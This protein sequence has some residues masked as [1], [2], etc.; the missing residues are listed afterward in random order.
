MITAAQQE[1]LDYVAAHPELEWVLHTD[2]KPNGDREAVVLKDSI[3]TCPYLVVPG[4]FLWSDKESHAFFMASDNIPGHDRELRL[5][6]LKACR[7]VI[8]AQPCH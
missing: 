5:A 1:I 2:E 8:E 3:S 7:L 4:P 6:I